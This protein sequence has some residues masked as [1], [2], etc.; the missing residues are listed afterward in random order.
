MHNLTNENQHFF[1]LNAKDVS[2]GRIPL[3]KMSA[4]PA[5]LNN[6]NIL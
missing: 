4:A 2:H 3:K 1:V 6:G 5:P